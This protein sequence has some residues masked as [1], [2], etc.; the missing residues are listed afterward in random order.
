LNRCATRL[1][2]EPVEVDLLG[3]I[4]GLVVGG[5][6]A[7]SRGLGRG[8]SDAVVEVEDGGGAARRVDDGGVG[9]GVHAGVDVAAGPLA[10][11]GKGGAGGGGLGGVRVEEGGGEEGGG[12]AGLELGVAVVG[13]LDDGVGEAGR[14]LEVQVELAVL[15]PVLDGG[16]GADVGVEA[17]EAEGDE[18]A[19]WRDGRADGALRAAVA[20]GLDRDD[21]QA[22]GRGAA[23]SDGGSRG[24]TGEEGGGELHVD[25]WYRELTLYSCKERVCR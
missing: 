13:R 10:A 16:A 4:D 14:V 12:D 6:L 3:K 2:A 7:G 18:L 5:D 24:H 25:G 15:G 22:G 19:V 23:G 21:G 9:D 11:A 20:G 17:V 1:A 8:K